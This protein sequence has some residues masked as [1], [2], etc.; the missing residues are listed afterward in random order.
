MSKKSKKSDDAIQTAE[1]SDL[2]DSS[3]SEVEST[4][5]N[6]S[7]KPNLSD[8][9]YVNAYLDC[10]SNAELQAKTGLSSASIFI[11]RK[12]LMEAGVKLEKYGHAKGKGVDVDALNAAIESRKSN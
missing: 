11:R 9:D 1:D 10:K 12:K 3:V 2:A 5:E 6:K 7:R 4:A 8:L